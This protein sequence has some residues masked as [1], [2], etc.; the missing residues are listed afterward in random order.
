VSATPLFGKYEPSGVSG[1][2]RQPDSSSTSRP[3]AS[4][5]DSPSSTR[6]AGTSQP[7]VSVMNR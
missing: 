4:I 7:H 1:T 3:A 2:G 6:P 5:G